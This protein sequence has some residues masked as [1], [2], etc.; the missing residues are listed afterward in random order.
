MVEACRAVVRMRRCRDHICE[1]NGVRLGQ[2][3]AGD[4]QAVAWR[5]EVWKRPLFL[6]V[7]RS[8][9]WAH[10]EL[11]SCFAGIDGRLREGSG[12]WLKSTRAGC[13]GL[14]GRLVEEGPEGCGAGTDGSMRS[15]LGL[16]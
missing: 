11:V 5:V 16:E 10:R 4:L 15:G 12:G 3:Q 9:V 13:V 1:G 6:R 8:E 14:H 7:R 2:V